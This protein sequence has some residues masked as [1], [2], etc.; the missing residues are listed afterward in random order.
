MSEVAGDVK[1]E[2]IHRTLREREISEFICQEMLYE[3]FAGLLDP[4]RKKAVEEFLRKS[5]TSQLEYQK[6]LRGVEFCARM[7]GVRLKPG[8]LKDFS[9]KSVS[10]E[11]ILGK[12]HWKN[13]P[14]SLRHFTQATAVAAMTAFLVTLLPWEKIP[15]FSEQEADRTIELVKI[16]MTPRQEPH[17]EV[18]DAGHEH[19]EEGVEVSFEVS[20]EE[21]I[22][23]HEVQDEP[24][25]Q[26][27][28]EVT[29]VSAP[30]SSAS[31]GEEDAA[32]VLAKAD[33]EVTPSQERGAVAV[34]EKS[35]QEET[36]DDPRFQGF[37]YRVTMNLDELDKKSDLIAEKI[38]SMG[39]KKAGKVDLGW[40]TKGGRYFHFSLPENQ[41]MEVISY[42]KSFG[43]VK[44]S[45]DAHRRVMP[46]GLVRFILWI[47]DFE[48]KK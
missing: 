24:S 46:K 35:L 12:G 1:V 14:E 28:P 38:R 13:W 3:H 42:L 16:G 17:G 47:E 30:T 26:A 40:K 27:A 22:A 8:A 18:A 31:V 15:V 44:L 37:V 20:P 4:Q 36:S 32:G 45:K 34:E 39:G 9:V 6:L 23:V 25:E 10:F 19:D 43:T 48:K 29:D 7:N 33:E 41:Q 11:K 2:K 21:Q 5:E